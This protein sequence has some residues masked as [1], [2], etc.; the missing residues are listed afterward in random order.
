MALT[1]ILLL[2]IPFS[3]S[4]IIS[5]CSAAFKLERFVCSVQASSLLSGRLG[6]ASYTLIVRLKCREI[7]LCALVFSDH[8]K[9]LF[10][11]SRLLFSNLSAVFLS[12]YNCIKF[13]FKES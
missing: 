10:R 2:E 7:K 8:C 6:V 12:P 13:L 9:F 4:G 5:I 11:P 3:K 1:S